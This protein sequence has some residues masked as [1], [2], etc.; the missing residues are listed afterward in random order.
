[1]KIGTSSI[2]ARLRV[3]NTTGAP[4]PFAAATFNDAAAHKGKSSTVAR[5][6]LPDEAGQIFRTTTD[7]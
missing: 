6:I 3:D 1:M 5:L 4:L 7:L 2:V